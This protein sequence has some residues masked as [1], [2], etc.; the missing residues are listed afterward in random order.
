MRDRDSDE[1]DH[2]AETDEEV[3]EVLARL[4]AAPRH[5]AHVVYQH[6]GAGRGAV[7]GERSDRHEQRAVGA[8]EQLSG[9]PR[10]LIELG[11]A[12]L[13][14]QRRGRDG[15]AAAQRAEPQGVEALVLQDPGE[16]LQQPDAVARADQI[17]QGLLDGGGDERGTEVQVPL[18]PLQ[19][20][21]I[22]E[23]HHGVGQG[24]ER[25]EQRN[26]KAERKP[27]GRSG[28]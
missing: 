8:L 9:G 22:D 13:G 3:K 5:K 1:R 12:D 7:D 2:R 25:E 16:E 24:A 14:W 23:R 4:R 15:L 18:E 19:G 20:E 26:D 10:V 21:P 6:E 11:A 28:R 17:L 27:H